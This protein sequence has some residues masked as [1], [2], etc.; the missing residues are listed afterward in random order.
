MNRDDIVQTQNRVLAYEDPN[1]QILS[2]TGLYNLMEKIRPQWQAKSLIQRTLKILPVDPS[3]ACQRIFNASIH[4]L[5]EKVIIAGLDIATATAEMY[6]LPKVSNEEDIIEKYDTSKL[7]TLAYRMGL[8]SRAEYRKIVRVYDIRKDLEHEDDQYEAGVADVIYVFESCISIILENDP[9]HILKIK[10]IKDIIENPKVSFLDASVVE[11]YRQAPTP[12]QEDIYKLLISTAL[13][14]EKADVVRESSY[15]AL[16]YLKEVTQPSVILKLAS[17]FTSNLNR[18]VPLQKEMRVASV[19]GMLPYLKTTSK[20]DYFT[21]LYEEFDLETYHW[22]NGAAHRDLLRTLEEVGGLS[23]I[24][25]EIKQ[26]YLEWLVLCYI[27]EPGGYGYY[28]A[29]RKVFYSNIGAPMAIDLIM[30]DNSIKNHE[31]EN[32]AEKSTKIKSLILDKFV[33]RRFDELL[34]KPSL[35]DE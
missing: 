4:D 32:I 6:K 13:N 24:P 30:N 9:V 34:D 8:L 29:T 33:R 22:S 20:K 3:S 10:D 11:D 21:K 12:R 31:I 18:R 1:L 35:E 19:S 25:K 7:I 14:N 16:A 23:N 15:N 26:K 17:D 27:G 5:R 2:N 28:G